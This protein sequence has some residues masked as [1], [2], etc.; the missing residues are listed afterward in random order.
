MGTPWLKLGLSIALGTV[1]LMGAAIPLFRTGPLTGRT[2]VIDPGH[3]G[4]RDLGAVAASGLLEKNVNLEVSLRLA[5]LLR[6]QGA[7]VQLTRTTD[8]IVAEDTTDLKARADLANQAKADLF[9]S[10]HHNDT[11]IPHDPRNDTQVYWKLDDEGPSRD[12][13]RLLLPRLADSLQMP[14]QRLIPGNFAVLRHCRRPAVLGEGAYLSNPT[15]AAL[16]AGPSGWQTEAEAYE[17]AIQ[18]YFAKGTPVL[19]AAVTLSGNQLQIPVSTDKS[20][21]RAVSVWIDDQPVAAQYR[22]QSGLITW[23]PDKPLTNG[24]H[25][26]RAM[27]RN[28]AGNASWPLE[29]QFTIARPAAIVTVAAIP[30]VWNPDL[31]SHALL[32]A[33]VRDAKGQPVADGTSVRFSIGR[34]SESAKTRAGKASAFVPWADATPLPATVTVDGVSATVQFATGESPPQLIVTVSGP[35]QDIPAAVVSLDGK[36]VGKVDAEGRM[37]VSAVPGHHVL[38]VSAPGYEPGN[39]ALDAAVNRVM[40]TNVTLTARYGGV[41][42]GKR[43]LIDPLTAPAASEFGRKTLSVAKQLQTRLVAAGATT[44]L[45]RRGGAQVAPDDRVRQA[46]RLEADLYIGLGHGDG[47]VAHYYTSNSGAR[48]ATLVHDQLKGIW[49][50]P[51]SSYLLSHTPCPAVIVRSPLQSPEALADAMFEAMRQYFTPPAAKS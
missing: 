36:T 18:A 2:I 25:R 22:A 20:P 45:T 51:E 19:G 34:R 15:S 44:V 13:G 41:L 35:G 37:A 11:T 4:P 47:R 5:E 9:L 14:R 21:I 27:A 33:Q 10:I 32:T 28:Q 39:I 43:I 1:L 16:L 46:G 6:K 50:A 12:F 38:I 23:Q 31:S 8:A 42:F 24:P 48:L 7:R 49:P 30:P 17:A 29:T 3:G 26:V 40:N